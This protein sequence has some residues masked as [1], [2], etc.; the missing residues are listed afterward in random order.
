MK[1]DSATGSAAGR[2]GGGVRWKGKAPDTLRNK[3]FKINVSDDEYD[4]IV[5]KAASLKISRTELVIRSVRDYKK[6]R[7]SK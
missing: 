2:K 3:Q 4:M 6:R 1:F 5:D 7:K